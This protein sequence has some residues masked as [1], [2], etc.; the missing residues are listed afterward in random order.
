VSALARRTPLRAKRTTPRRRGAT[1]SVRT[2]HRRPRVLGICQTH[3]VARADRVVAA[4]VKKRDGGCVVVHGSHGGGLQWSHLISRRYHATR[5]D[6]D[7]SVA[8]CAAH[9]V[10]FTHHPLEFEDWRGFWCGPSGLEMLKRTA[11]AS[12]RPDLEQ[13]ITTYGGAA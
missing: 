4:F 9:H 13:I 11:L 1:C 5:W 7:A 3:A 6:P 8:M 12:A 2:C 10:W